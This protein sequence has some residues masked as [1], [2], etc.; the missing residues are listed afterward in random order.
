[1]KES[2]TEIN[3]SDIRTKLESIQQRYK[4]I[5]PFSVEEIGL[6]HE[7]KSLFKE[8]RKTGFKET[9]AFAFSLLVSKFEKNFFK[10]CQEIP[11]IQ[12]GGS[13]T[14]PVALRLIKEIVRHGDAATINHLT[15]LLTR[16]LSVPNDTNSALLRDSIRQALHRDGKSSQKAC[17]QN[18]L[19]KLQAAMNLLMTGR[20]FDKGEDQHYSNCLRW[21]ENL[22]ESE[23][24]R[25][26]K[27][28]KPFKTPTARQVH[29]STPVPMGTVVQYGFDPKENKYPKLPTMVNSS[30][31]SSSSSTS[32]GSNPRALFSSSTQSSSSS[33]SSSSTSDKDDGLFLMP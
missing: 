22:K 1:M 32:P 6:G 2:K 9:A 11:S 25:F 24:N 3:T 21:F 23:I 28:S 27:D 13:K 7:L 29:S 10:M 20:Q 17:Y 26:K 15:T 12:G 4:N 5:Q 16:A 31:S 8:A 14:S 18:D 19:P 33:S 30:S